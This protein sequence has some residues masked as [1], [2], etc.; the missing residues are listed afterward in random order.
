MMK[1]IFFLLPCVVLIVAG[2]NS[3][4]NST[5]SPDDNIMRYSR[6]ITIED[7]TDYSIA[8]IRNPWDTTKLLASYYLVSRDNEVPAEIRNGAGRIVRVPLK[9]VV[10]YSNIYIS[11]LSELG[12]PD[13]VKGVCDADYMTDSI[14][15]KNIKKGLIADCGLSTAPNIEKIMMVN[16]EAIILSPMDNA[17][18]H[19]KLDNIGITLIEGAEYTEETPLARAEWMRFFGR[20]VGEKEKS[21]SL[22]N[23]V[24][25]EYLRLMRLAREASGHPTVIFDGIYGNQW[26][27]PTSRSVSGA[28]IRD[29]GGINIFADYDN[30]GSAHLSPEEVIFKGADA[31]FWLVRYYNSKDYSLSDWLAINKSY[32]KFKPVRTGKIYGSN[33]SVSGIFDDAAFHPQWI[34]A[35]M[36][37]LLHPELEIEPPKRYFNQLK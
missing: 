25:K 11:L 4:G 21:D 13:I 2:C 33:T 29:A 17:N 1:S 35:D 37:S 16:P 10:I 34:L 6:N 7:K 8:K 5:T 15:L 3:R 24:E 26:N 32:S 27:V 22:F 36:V 18:G 28:L 23:E 14:V 20:L 31:D 9:D 12:H 19:G 30:V